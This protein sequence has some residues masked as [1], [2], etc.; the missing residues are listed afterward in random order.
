MVSIKKIYKNTLLCIKYPFLY[1]RN[2]FT[3]NHYNN[4]A[5]H[6]KTY[7]LRNNYMLMMSVAVYTDK[8]YAE[9]IEKVK[10]D[11]DVNSP[12][13]I[14]GKVINHNGYTISISYDKDKF[15]INVKHG[16]EKKM[17]VYSMDKYLGNSGLTYKDISG[18]FFKS[19]V[20]TN[21]CNNKIYSNSVLLVLKDGAEKE[22]TYYSF[23]LIKINLRPFIG[24][25][26]RFLKYLDS[27]LGLFHILPSYTE[28]DAI[29]NGW[30]KR[31]G[32]DIC[33]EIRHSLLNTYFQKEQPTKLTDKIRCF[34]NGVK[35]LYSYTILQIK[36]KYGSLRWYAYGDTEDT[37]KIID[38]Y[39]DL[40]AKTCIV[41]GKDAEY[42]STGWICPFCDEH[43]P[44]NS[45]KIGE[46]NNPF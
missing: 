39:E 33:K 40:S 16:D 46:Y 30:R 43:K 24:L 15:Y 36:E 21:I 2:R 13:T 45:R 14:I 6:N 38:K 19:V 41:C 3:G 35:L 44:E 25:E 27:F 42:M 29:E 5:I 31:F 18:V 12:I 26:L 8:E 11:K 10:S 7:K 17:L 1:P 20:R 37:I 23:D 32:E 4:M 28:L 34:Y 22:K 9:L